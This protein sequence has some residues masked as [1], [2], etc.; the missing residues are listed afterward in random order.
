MST[1][2]LLH[3]LLLDSE[4]HSRSKNVTSVMLVIHKYTIKQLKWNM[5]FLRGKVLQIFCNIIYRLGNKIF[6]IHD[7]EYKWEFFTRKGFLNKMRIS[8]QPYMWPKQFSLYLCL[9][10]FRNKRKRFLVRRQLLSKLILQQ[11][12]LRLP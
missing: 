1:K 2:S 4:N 6:N 12:F 7:A 11:S 10:I 8:R 3:M 5:L 9:C